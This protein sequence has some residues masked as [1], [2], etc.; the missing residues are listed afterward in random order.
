MRRY[1]LRI[2]P[3]KAEW[4]IAVEP[5]TDR[6]KWSGFWVRGVSIDRHLPY[7]VEVP[8]AGARKRA[9]KAHYADAEKG[10]LELARQ[11]A[12]ANPTLWVDVLDVTEPDLPANLE[13]R[14]V[15]RI[16]P[17]ALADVPEYIALGGPPP[18]LL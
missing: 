1:L 16:E 4:T 8:R 10:L 12:A 3:G 9:E 15:C 5:P 6:R 11:V 7:V 17:R 18:S 13:R 2:R 14:I